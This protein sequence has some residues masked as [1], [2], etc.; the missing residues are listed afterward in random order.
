MKDT[1]K[2]RWDLDGRNAHIVLTITSAAS[3]SSNGEILAHVGINCEGVEGLPSRAIFTEE[4][5][6]DIMG[7]ETTFIDYQGNNHLLFE[8]WIKGITDE[9]R[10]QLKE[11]KEEYKKC[12]PVLE[13]EIQ[14]IE[15]LKGSLTIK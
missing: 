10:K 15:S 8:N 11:Y 14:D 6:V 7:N 13:K 4:G 9:I 5:T 12:Y 2:I 1:K 3:I